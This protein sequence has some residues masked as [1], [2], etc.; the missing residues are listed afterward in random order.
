MTHAVATHIEMR[1]NRDGQER[2]YIA[3]S[4]V[5]VQDVST[6]AEIQGKTPDEI[7]ESL[8]HLTLAQVH[9]ALSYYFDDREAILQ[10]MREDEGFVSGLRSLRGIGILEQKLKSPLGQPGDPVPS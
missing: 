9:A 1:P 3:G 7:V 4:R 2:A 5:R 10:E 6:L 8:P